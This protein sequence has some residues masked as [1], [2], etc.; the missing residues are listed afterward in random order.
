MKQE[1]QKYIQIINKV[2]KPALGCT[3]PIAAAYAT[4]VAVKQLGG[5]IPDS[6]EVYVSDNLYKNS[7][8]VFVPKTGRVGLAIAAAAGAAGGNEKAEL[9]VLADITP[10]QVKIAQMMV[11]EGKVTVKRCETE[12]FIYCC[13]TATIADEES[14][15]EV[16]GGHTNITEM[17][18]NG[19]ITLLAERNTSD[20]TGSVCEGVDISIQ[21]IYDF[22]QSVNFADISFILEASRLN[23]DLSDEGMANP[24]GLEV[25]RTLKASVD[26]G[27]AS[28]DLF[29]KIVERS[30]CAAEEIT[31]LFAFPS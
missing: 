27:M 8:G 31:S 15:V 30:R 22:A 25:G 24:Y 26:K 1:W 7:M 13:V 4:A 18:L 11:D 19:N 12:E 5:R 17:Q 3:E 6:L 28:D 20:A 29:N 10:E 2:V 14:F 16:S 21:S 9:Q 23:G